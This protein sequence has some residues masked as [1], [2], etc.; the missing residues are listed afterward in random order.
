[1]KDFS[2]TM[3]MVFNATREL[4]LLKNETAR[5][6]S[7]VDSKVSDCYHILEIIT[8]NAAQAARVT[9]ELRSL[10]KQRREAK[11]KMILIETV[12]ANKF[13]NTQLKDTITKKSEERASKYA[14]EAKQAYVRIFGKSAVK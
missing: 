8:L 6:M 13:E 2:A 10:L 14:G 9:K 7:A 11:E 5:M 3:D 12:L 4:H 1:M